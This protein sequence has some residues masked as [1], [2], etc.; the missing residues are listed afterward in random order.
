MVVRV[1]AENSG[2]N[3][4]EVV[5]QLKAAHASGE[6]QAGLD[7]ESGQPKDLSAA[8]IVDLFSAK[9]ISLPFQRTAAVDRHLCKNLAGCASRPVST[10]SDRAKA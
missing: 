3:A 10:R 4:T 7:I 8:G 5:G 2:L 1:V 6:S 9:V